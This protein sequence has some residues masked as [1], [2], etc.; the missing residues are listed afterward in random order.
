MSEA[1][2]AHLTVAEALAKLPGPH[3][4]RYVTL[5]ERGTLQVEIYAPRGYDRQ[6]PHT[7]DELYVVAEGSGV[8]YNGR[9]RHPFRRGDFLFVAAGTEH[10]FEEFTDDFV[11]WV[12]FY[13]PDGGEK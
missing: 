10:R 3:G 11:T 12:L 9:E 2:T 8:F 13:G 5:F 4:A 6:T 7:R 1:T